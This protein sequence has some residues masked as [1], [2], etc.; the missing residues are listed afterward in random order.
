MIAAKRQHVRQ[1]EFIE[2]IDK[3]HFAFA[4]QTI[5]KH[6][7]K[8]ES[9]RLELANHPGSNLRFALLLLLLLE[10]FSRFG[11]FQGQGQN[12][13]FD[14]AIGCDRN[15]AIFS[16]ADITAGLP[17]DV[18]RTGSLLAISGCVD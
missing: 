16:L 13:S 12:H 9:H 8:G 7:F 11:H 14:S 10:S 18:V 2:H 4:I 3:I 1:F 17:F 6:Q 15:N 5:G